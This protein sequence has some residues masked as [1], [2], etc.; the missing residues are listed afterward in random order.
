MIGS[1][2]RHFCLCSR[3]M[4]CN[5]RYRQECLCGSWS[6]MDKFKAEAQLLCNFS[7]S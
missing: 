7:L 3:L 4:P 5:D 2:H 6:T 1:C